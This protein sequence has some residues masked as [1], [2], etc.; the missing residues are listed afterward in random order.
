MDMIRVRQGRNIRMVGAAERVLVDLPVPAR[1]V[2]CSEDLYGFRPRLTIAVGNR[3]CVGSVLAEDQ[4]DP[5]RRLVSPASGTIT[6][7]RRGARRAISGIV[8]TCDGRQETVPITK[9]AASSI[10]GLTRERIVQHLLES[11][12]WI[13]FR[14]RPFDR[15]VDPDRLPKAIFVPAVSTGP[16]AP[17]PGFFLKGR[18]DLFQYGLEILTR[19]T[20]GCVHVCVGPKAAEP[21]ASADGRIRIHRVVGPHPAG[22][23]GTHIHYLDPLER[24]ERVWYA[25]VQGVVAIARSF[26]DGGFCPE[27]IIAVTGARAPERVYKRTILGAEAGFIAGPNLP[28]D[29]CVIFGGVLT[30]REVGADGAVGLYDAEVAVIPRGGLRVVLGWM[31][32]G[33]H[34][35]SF[36]RTMLSSWDPLRSVSLT[37]DRF[38]SHRPIVLNDVYDRYVALDVPTFFLIKAILSENIDEME[39]LGILECSPEDFALAAF[40]CPSKTDVCGIIR[41]GLSMMEAEG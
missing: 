16:L 9:Y 22:N 36:T 34:A 31:M 2:V 13:F 28:A 29:A 27:R 24:G 41:K 18:E 3:V 23:V 5:R 15:I 7:I 1:V 17:D 14:E 38:G 4:G 40:A 20:D 8:I 12:A 37:T 39:R 25:D 21:S 19:L 26:I 11:G 35:Y 6:E 30:G 32:P 33:W 10:S